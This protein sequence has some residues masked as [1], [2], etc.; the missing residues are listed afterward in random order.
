MMTF[1]SLRMSRRR[2]KIMISKHSSTNWVRTRDKCGIAVLGMK[3]LGG[4]G[5]M[6]RHGGIT[7]RQGF[8]VCPESVGGNR[9]LRHELDGGL[10][11][12]LAVAVPF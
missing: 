3:S 6:V 1:E 9:D 12:N 8:A 7:A 10:H 11:Q 2:S 4:K 5:E